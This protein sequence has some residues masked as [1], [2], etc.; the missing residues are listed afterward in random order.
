[1]AKTTTKTNNK[2]IEKKVESLACL[3]QCQCGGPLI[4]STL[5]PKTERFTVTCVDCGSVSDVRFPK[6]G[7]LYTLDGTMDDNPLK[8]L[9]RYYESDNITITDE[10][11]ESTPVSKL[12]NTKHGSL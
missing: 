8:L 5:A 11:I 3:G 10:D 12:V 1:M 7:D 9:I 2:K 6:R 4:I